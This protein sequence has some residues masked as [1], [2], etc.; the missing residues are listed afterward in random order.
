MLENC[1]LIKTF[2]H[3][4]A[5]NVRS[6]SMLY[7]KS[8]GRRHAHSI[9]LSVL[10]LYIVFSRL[11]ARRGTPIRRVASARLQSHRPRAERYYTVSCYDKSNRLWHN[12]HPSSRDVIV[13][14]LSHAR[15]FFVCIDIVQSRALARQRVVEST[16]GQGIHICTQLYTIH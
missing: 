3:T 5:S 8:N 7:W 4:R 13:A 6:R 14:T 1:I 11:C 10:W 9:N 16:R 2:C 15:M 12:N